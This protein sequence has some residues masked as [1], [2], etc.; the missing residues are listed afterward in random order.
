ML[1]AR[2]ALR[3][4]A[5]RFRPCL[6]LVMYERYHSNVFVAPGFNPINDHPLSAALGMQEDL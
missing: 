5:F 3:A 6:L 1:P 2:G 4:L